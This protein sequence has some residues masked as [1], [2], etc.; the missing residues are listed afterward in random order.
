MGQFYQNSLFLR[1]LFEFLELEPKVVDPLVPAL[2]PRRFDLA[3]PAGKIVTIVGPN[4]AGKSTLVKLLCRF[5]DPE[6]GSIELDGQDLRGFLLED[7]RRQIAVLFQEPV[8]YS[9]TVAENIRLGD[10]RLA[11]D[12]AGLNRRRGRRAPMELSHNCLGATTTCW[13]T[14]LKRELS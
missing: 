8:H 10:L 2:A 13:E 4:G 6:E 5:Y 12:G 3:I 11:K 14:C 7:L 1:D 9:A